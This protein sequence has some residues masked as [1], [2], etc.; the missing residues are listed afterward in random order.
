[1]LSVHVTSM[2]EGCSSRTPPPMNKPIA[3]SPFE[4]AN[5]S[6]SPRVDARSELTGPPW[7]TTRVLAQRGVSRTRAIARLLELGIVIVWG[8]VFAAWLLACEG[9]APEGASRQPAKMADPV[10]K[11]S[12]QFP[13]RT[14][15][16][17][18]KA[19]PSARGQASATADTPGRISVRT[20]DWILV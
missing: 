18:A 16:E 4:H 14:P 10:A 8:T 1:M 5:I 11:G 7:S 19:A 17:A 20:D 3:L 2:G 9:A 6:S 15:S 13:V 12:R